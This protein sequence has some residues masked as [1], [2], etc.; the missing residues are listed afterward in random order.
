MNKSQ[1][2]DVIDDVLEKIR[3][4]S[5]NIEQT[6]SVPAF[7]NSVYVIMLL[8]FGISIWYPYRTFCNYCNVDRSEFELDLNEG[9]NE[10]EEI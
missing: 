3:H 10:F 1:I 8:A 6:T 5:L 9:E 2:A 4:D 7:G